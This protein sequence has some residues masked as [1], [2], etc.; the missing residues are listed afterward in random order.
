MDSSYQR[1]GQSDAAKLQVFKS[2]TRNFYLHKSFDYQ[3]DLEFLPA[4]PS[5]SAFSAP[6]PAD[7]SSFQQMARK[8]PTSPQNASPNM[9]SINLTYVTQQIVDLLSTPRARLQYLNQNPEISPKGPTAS[10]NGMRKMQQQPYQKPT[11]RGY[12]R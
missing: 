2:I 7:V 11:Q 6:S 5:E 3:S 4:I 8:N 10:L 1:Y 9:K 12:V